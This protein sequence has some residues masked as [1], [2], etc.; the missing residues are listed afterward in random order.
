MTATLP[1]GRLDVRL[2]EIGADTLVIHLAGRLDVPVLR[3]LLV[4]LPI[5][6]PWLVLDLAGVPEF[7]PG[8]PAALTA[9][10]RGLRRR[11]AELALWQ[12]RAQPRQIADEEFLSRSV[13][14]IHGDLSGW[15][16]RRVDTQPR[17]PA[18]GA[19]HTPSRRPVPVDR[20]SRPPRRVLGGSRSAAAPER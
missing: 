18:P 7:H 19:R 12:L 11:G 1:S 17:G 20:P 9:V 6:R 16:A 10:H 4:R 2:E 8:T 3:R 15:L 13:K 5:T 14:V